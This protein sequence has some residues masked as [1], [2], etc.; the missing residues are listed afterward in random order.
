MT[1]TS[2]DATREQSAHL[3]RLDSR[4][5]STL[6]RTTAHSSAVWSL[7]KDLRRLT[8]ALA[9]TLATF[10]TVSRRQRG[11]AFTAAAVSSDAASDARSGKG[12]VP[13]DRGRSLKALSMYRGCGR[14]WAGR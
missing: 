8:T 3:G 11:K 12:G 14:L 13:E 6:G 5:V 1:E 2:D 9:V 4:M 7:E 10:S